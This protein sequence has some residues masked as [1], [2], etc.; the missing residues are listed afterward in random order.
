MTDYANFVVLQNGVVNA[1]ARAVFLVAVMG[2]FAEIGVPK[3]VEKL[4]AWV[5]SLG[6]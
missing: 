2:S 5:D 3:R 4:Q 1:K 6:Y